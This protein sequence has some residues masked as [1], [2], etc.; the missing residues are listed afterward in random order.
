MQA[1]NK[2]LVWRVHLH[3]SCFEATDVEM[4][5]NIAEIA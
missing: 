2:I 1:S 4:T 3:A 5:L